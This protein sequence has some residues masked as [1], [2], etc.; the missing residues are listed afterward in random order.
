MK[1]NKACQKK[2]L[3]KKLNEMNFRGPYSHYGRL[4]MVYYGN[5]LCIPLQDE[6]SI[7]QLRAILQI[8]NQI[9]SETE[10]KH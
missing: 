7:A 10:W 9:V 3:I 2:E 4:Y 6:F 1:G 5:V 8:V